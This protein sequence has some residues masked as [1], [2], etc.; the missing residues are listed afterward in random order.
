MK[1]IAPLQ[2]LD[3]H[4]VFSFFALRRLSCPKKEEKEFLPF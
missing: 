1:I 4:N 2:K 3:T